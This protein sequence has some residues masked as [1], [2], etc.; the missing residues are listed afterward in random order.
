MQNKSER[1]NLI[2]TFIVANLLTLIC[3][4][5]PPPKINGQV[6][7][8]LQKIKIGYHIMKTKIVTL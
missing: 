6:S 1:I 3:I 4:F 5:F 8:G 7:L 2:V